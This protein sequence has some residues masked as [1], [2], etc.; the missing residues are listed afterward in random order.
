[1]KKIIA[2]LSFLGI[3]SF[4]WS[5]AI[6][7]QIKARSI[8][9]QIVQSS[10]G[11]GDIMQGI[12]MPP[13]EV[14]GDYYLNDTWN[15]STVLIYGTDAMIDGYY[16]KYNLK[17]QKLEIKAPPVTRLLPSS[18]I[19]S[20][21]WFDSPSQKPFYF[22]NANEYSL[23]GEQQ[24]GLLEIVVDGKLPLVRSTSLL[25]KKPDYNAAFNVGTND[26]IIYKRPTLYYAQDMELVKI[27][28]KKQL[29]GVFEDSKAMENYMKENSLNPNKDEDLVQ[30]FTYYNKPPSK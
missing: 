12:P 29:L 15:I 17:D 27:K 5:Q 14:I 4:C 18:K 23:D 8:M 25:I 7:E 9:G 2:T 19:N 22:V 10:G 28:N 24:T 11:N 1:M 26:E 13:G 20:L 6:P 3:M 21:V 30:I 16:V